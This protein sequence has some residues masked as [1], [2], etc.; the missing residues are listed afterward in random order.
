MPADSVALRSDSMY[1][2]ADL[3]LHSLHM[4]KDPLPMTNQ[5]CET[6]KEPQIWSD[7]VCICLKALFIN[8]TLNC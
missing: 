5:M 8:V 6:Q 3:V 4:S 1:M 7:T 2:H